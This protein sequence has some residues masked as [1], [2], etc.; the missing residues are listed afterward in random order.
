MIAAK[1]ADHVKRRDR[2]AAE[3]EGRVARERLLED[4][5]R[6]PGQAVVIGD[7]AIERLR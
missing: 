6:I 5:D 2:D 3:N 1:T 4:A 7:G